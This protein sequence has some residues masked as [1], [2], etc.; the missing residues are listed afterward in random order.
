MLFSQ[1]LET[2]K[3]GDAILKEYKI[4]DDPNI[5]EGASIEKA[6]ENQISFLEKGSYLT[7]KLEETK[8]SAL[9]LPNDEMLIKQATQLKFSWAIFEDP[10]LAFAET[11][12]LLNPKLSPYIGV[13]K[14]AVIGENVILGED[15]SIGANV[16]IGN[17]SKIGS[18]SIIHPGVVIYEKVKIGKNN[19]LHSNCVIHSK[20]ILRD[21][22]IVHANAVIGS[23]GFGFVPTKKGWRKMPQTGSVVIEQDVEIGCSTTIDRPAVGETRIGAGTKIDNLVQ[24]GHGVHIGKG[25]AMASQVGIAGG[26]K[27]G[28]GVILAGQVG[29][30]NRVKV[31]DNVIASSKCGITKDVP[32]G[33]V[34]SGFPAIPNKLWLRCYASFKKLPELVKSIQEMKPKKAT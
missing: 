3:L 26:A 20:S 19:E 9:L 12:D 28:N 32:S 6:I 29:I 27:I 22:C 31:G 18:K 23:E 34:V 1:L 5:N 14:T 30:A 25:C 8:A 7:N 11:L 2:L 10:R 15:V 17:N 21:N 4:N 24:V 13:H 33:T 16:F